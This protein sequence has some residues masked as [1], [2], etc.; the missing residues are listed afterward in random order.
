MGGR[1]VTQHN[2]GFSMHFIK[3]FGK[4]VFLSKNNRN[5]L[6]HVKEKRNRFFY[7]FPKI[8]NLWGNPRH[9]HLCFQLILSL[10]SLSLSTE[11]QHHSFLQQ[12]ASVPHRQFAIAV[13]HPFEVTK[14]KK[15]CPQLKSVCNNEVLNKKLLNFP[16]P[17]CAF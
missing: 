10:V 9:Q 1:F 5:F 11:P 15:L 7:F 13:I 17:V 2:T 3:Y 4:I 8:Y 14:R 16:F 12:S 6:F